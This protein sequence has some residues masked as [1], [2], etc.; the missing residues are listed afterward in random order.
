MYRI[1]IVLLILTSSCQKNTV[2]QEVP[3]DDNFIIGN[4]QQIAREYSIGGPL[5]LEEIENGPIS[6]FNDNFQF[7]IVNYPSEQTNSGTYSV[8]AD[9]L[10]MIYDNDLDK[11]EYVFKM[12]LYTNGELKLIPLGPMICIEGCSSIYKKTN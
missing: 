10:K 7:S 5:L 9:T 6:K 3:V 11:I 1:L 8:A 12:T 2:L 4:W